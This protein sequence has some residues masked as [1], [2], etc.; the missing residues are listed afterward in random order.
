MTDTIRDEIMR[1]ISEEILKKA[2]EY[3]NELQRNMIAQPSQDDIIKE[4]SK[5]VANEITKIVSQSKPTQG[6]I[7]ELTPETMMQNIPVQSPRVVKP[8]NNYVNLPE[9][10]Q[11]IKEKSE[12]DAFGKYNTAVK[13]A[14]ALT[15]LVLAGLGAYMSGKSGLG[16]GYGAEIG[17]KA[18]L[19]VPATYSAITTKTALPYLTDLQMRLQQEALESQ[20]AWEEYKMRLEE[21]LKLNTQ[22]TLKHIDEQIERLRQE[23]ETGRKVLQLSVESEI[24]MAK[25]SEQKRWHDIMDKYYT[26]L[27][28]IRRLLA[29]SEMAIGSNRSVLDKV[30]QLINV[31]NDLQGRLQ[32]AQIMRDDMSKKGK[33]YEQSLRDLDAQILDME[34]TINDLNKLIDALVKY[35]ILLTGVSPTQAQAGQ[36]TQGIEVYLKQ[37][38]SQKGKVEPQSAQTQTTNQPAT[39]QQPNRTGGYIINEMLKSNLPQNDT[40]TNLILSDLDSLELLGSQK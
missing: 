19:T 27:L 17:A 18:G 30:S 2:S 5:S 28:K 15:P 23:A 37:L 40:L 20:R 6:L 8:L 24:E 16:A 29:E 22:K 1:Q 3:Y 31:K 7:S 32:I 39:T 12:F 14:S 4:I 34:S 25:L 33:K 26:E 21:E 10:L 36:P 38:Y 11:A 9:Y 13:I 35:Q